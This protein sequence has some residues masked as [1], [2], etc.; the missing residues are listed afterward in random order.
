MNE[1]E[2]LT[3]LELEEEFSR[4][5]DF[6]KIFDKP[7]RRYLVHYLYAKIQGK[8]TQAASPSFGDSPEGKYYDYLKQTLD[9]VF[10]KDNILHLAQ[11]NPT[12]SKQLIAD[13]IK[14]LRD[15]DKKV[16]AD[17]PY[18]E[19]IDR[20]AAWSHRPTH[21]WLD[22]WGGLLDYLAQIYPAEELDT[23][24]YAQK[25]EDLIA[26]TRA[27]V[28]DYDPQ[29]EKKSRF[30]ILVADLLA[31]WD[32]LLTA[33]TLAYQLEEI[34]KEREAFCRLL[35]AKVDELERLLKLVSP[36]SMEAGRYWDMSRALWKNTGFDVLQKYAQ[37]LENESSIQE[38][39]DLLGRMRTA[40]IETEEEEYSHVIVRKSWIDD[41]QLRS[42]IGGIRQSDDLNNV[43]PGELALLGDART[44]TLF[45]Q[46]YAD[47]S[48]S[49]WQYQGKRLVTDDKVQYAKREKQK[50]K[51]KGPFIV[52]V[53]TSGSMHGTPAQIAKTLC[54]AILKMAAKENRKAYLISFSIGTK[55]MPLHDIAS[56]L[57]KI[58]EF[59]SMSF[60][61]GTDATPAL[62]E[63]LSMLKTND[64]R[65]AD[66]LMVSDFVMYDMRE[67][68]EK[69]IRNEKQKDTRFH[70][71]AISTQANPE[72]LE[73]FDHNWIYNPDKKEIIRQ[74]WQ[75][76]QQLEA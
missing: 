6:G 43:L 38:L 62:S 1:V 55:T 65:E 71:L 49:S 26:E 30:D 41:P 63:A 42:E 17:N 76:L 32:A 8:T 5:I 47:K 12:L 29:A 50:R 28:K 22:T 52:C 46:R 10:A 60:D 51:E 11:D 75:D 57:E 53:D 2:P 20:F 19:E 74:M 70:S 73:V 56:S 72:I 27:M 68:L 66:V 31:Q 4:F 36:F 16:N 39:V 48:L 37:L 21:L 34:E 59:L 40:Q 61:G 3:A 7:T 9:E 45:M 35:Y 58:V 67:D 69:R 13:T 64:Y 33:K 14:W 23:D 25:F 44:E 15:T 24:F 54:F 18:Q